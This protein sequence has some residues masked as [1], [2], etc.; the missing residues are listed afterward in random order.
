MALLSFLCLRLLCSPHYMAF[1]PLRMWFKL[2][3]SGR[4]DPYPP[5]MGPAH[6]DEGQFQKFCSVIIM[7][8]LLLTTGFG[9]HALS[10]REIRGLWH[11]IL[12]QLLIVLAP[13][14]LNAFIYMVMGRIVHF[15]VPDRKVFSITVWRLIIFF[16]LLDII[17]FVVQGSSSSL[18]SLTDSRMR[19]IG[20][21]ICESLY[22][23]FVLLF[24]FGHSWQYYQNI[25]IHTIVD[26][27]GMGL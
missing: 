12:M 3:N 2:S 25:D 11:F 9:I 18:L 8:G 1:P 15:F 10:A 6:T 21:N 20:S 13:L 26:M 22:F 17:A 24:F 16:V 19:K 7:A 23:T 14:W 5:I 4:S 27:G